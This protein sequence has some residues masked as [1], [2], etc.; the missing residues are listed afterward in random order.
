M[1]VAGATGFTKAAAGGIL[2]DIYLGPANRLINQKSLVYGRLKRDRINVVGRK[3]I[4]PVHMVVNENVVSIAA[5]GQSP[6]PASQEYKAAEVNTKYTYGR[7]KLPG[8]LIADMKSD[9]GS[10]LRAVE[11]EMQ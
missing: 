6:A 8:P 3:A 2:K 9:M 11:S 7:I 5:G 1:A 4:V 10:F